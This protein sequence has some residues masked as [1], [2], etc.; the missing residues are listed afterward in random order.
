VIQRY[1][2]KYLP[3]V[4]QRSI[5]IIT[6]IL[7]SFFIKFG[8]AICGLILV[9]ITLN[10]I[11]SND[12]GVWMTISSFTTWFYFFD[13]GLANGFRNKFT[14]AIALNDDLLAK[15]Y[16][17]TTYA[18]IIIICL[19]LIIVFEI[20]NIFL[21]WNRILNTDLN[22][23]KL[24]ILMQFLFIFLCLK[25]VLS[26]VTTS[27]IAFHK[28]AIS[29][30]IELLSSLLVLFLIYIASQ[31][32]SSSILW[33]AFIS[34]FTP[35]VVLL[36]ASFLLFSTILMKYKPSIRAIDFSLSKFLFSKGIQF[37]IIQLA[38]TL[39][40][41]SNN[42]VISQ[43]FTPEHVTTFSIINKYFAI[44]IMGFGIVMMPIWSSFTDAYHKNDI[45]WIKNI[46][47]K[48]LLVWIGLAICLLIMSYFLPNVL[49][50]WIKRKLV[51]NQSLVIYS[52]LFVLISSWNTIF[53]NFINSVDKIRVQ[54]ISAIALV[55]MYLPISIFC[56]KNL[57]MGIEGVMLAC[58]ICLI[59]GS[60]LSAYQYYLIINNKAKGIW[61][62]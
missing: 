45:L 6:N 4:K 57:G 16:I 29:N 14:Q 10:Y 3:H 19:A 46:I 51:Y 30:V 12:Y 25:M 35:I 59:P 21:D 13:I 54:F 17:S 55:I 23:K 40:F 27:L 58:C 39:M 11:E 62:K 2:D 56:C 5:N 26:I 15:K 32:T 41:T 47:K 49:H 42:I 53:W 52:S 34:S 44:P 37:F 36:I 9:P 7:Y 18:I 43:L 61:F 28:V 22:A 20:L 50:F 33:V 38:V 24:T 8:I 48:L 1:F 60:I 31:T